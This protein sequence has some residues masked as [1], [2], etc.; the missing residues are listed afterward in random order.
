METTLRKYIEVASKKKPA[1]LVIK[2]AKIVNVFTKEIMEKDVAICEGMI[3]GIG[4]YEGKSVHNA[5]GQYLVPGFI[6]GHVHIESSLLSPSEFSKV[7]LLHGVTT[8]VTDPHEIGNIAGSTGL[9]FMIE[10]ARQTLMNIFFM[11]PSCVPVTPFETNGANLNAKKLAPFLQKPEVLGLAEVM[12]Y[13]A[14]ANNET[15]IL[16]KIQLMHQHKKKIDGHA[17]GIGMEELNVY[18]AAGIRTDHEATT[19]KEAKERLDLGMYLMVR[20]GTV[21]KDLASLL[22]AITPENSRRCF[23]VT[24]D[25]LINDLV[26]EGSID[27]IVRQAI[28]L[29]IDPLQAIQMAT[30][31]AA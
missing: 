12:N 6:D 21:A 17:A 2:H 11:L 15:D 22:P 28:A 5:N 26:K 3:V 8:V 25:K 18:P 31:N 27:H 30:L 4:E 1:D 16:E 9:E 20:E 13:Q 24:D 29:G 19:A 23:F 7:S 10:D 14:V